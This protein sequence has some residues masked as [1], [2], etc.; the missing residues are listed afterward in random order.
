LYLGNTMVD[1]WSGSGSYSISISGKH[2]VT[3]GKSYRLE[4][5]YSINGVKKPTVSTM[6]TCP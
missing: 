6:S 2:K 3:S 5:T 4:L 1:S